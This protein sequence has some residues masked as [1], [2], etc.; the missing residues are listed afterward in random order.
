VQEDKRNKCR[1]ELNLEA[2]G[3]GVRNS[4]SLE[5]L[6]KL[7]AHPHPAPQNGSELLR[8][9]NVNDSEHFHHYSICGPTKLKTYEE[10][11][12]HFVIQ[13]HK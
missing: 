10:D 11:L 7:K 8:M 4:V 9:M 13:E 1:T 6:G 3:V 2:G 5:T 12:E